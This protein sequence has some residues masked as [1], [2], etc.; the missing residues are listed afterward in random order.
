MKKRKIKFRLNVVIGYTEDINLNCYRPPL[1]DVFKHIAW[2]HQLEY[3]I[4]EDL[5][6]FSSPG[7]DGQSP[8]SSITDL[9][10]FRS[11]VNTQITAKDLRKIVSDIFGKS[12]LWSAGVDLFCQLHKSLQEFP[13]PKEYYFC[14]NFPFVEAHVGGKVTDCIPYDYLIDVLSSDSN[15]Q[16]N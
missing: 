1:H 14:R 10:Y 11:T 13:F 9:V 16:L 15:P 3:S 8:D 6:V 7:S 5:K 4:T 12:L 2:L